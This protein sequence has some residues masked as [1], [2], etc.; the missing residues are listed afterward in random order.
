MNLLFRLIRLISPYR[1]WMLLAV[2]LSYLTVGSSIGLMMTSAW[3][4]AKAALH[5][6]IADLQVAIVGV[7][8]FGI[9]RGVFRYLE[10][11][12][13]HEATFRIL[14]RLRAWF[15]S[16]IEPLVPSGL[17]QFRTADLLSRIAGDVDS[18]EHF[19]IR[20]LAPPAGAVLVLVTMIVLLGHLGANFALVFAVFFLIGGIVVPLFTYWISRSLGRDLV[21]LRSQLSLAAVDAVQG[22]PD[23]LVYGRIEQRLDEFDALNRRYTRL[24]NRL[25]M[26]E[27][28]HE[29]LIGLIMNLAVIGVLRTAAVQMSAGLLDGVLVSVLVLGTMA[30][31]EAVFPLPVAAQHAEEIRRAGVRLF[32]LIG[33][34]P[35]SLLTPSPQEITRPSGEMLEL[36]DVQFTYPGEPV[37]ALEGVSFRLARGQ[38]IALVGP[39]GAGKSTVVNL[40]L[41]FWEPQ[42]GSLLL[43]G[44]P[45]SRI[46]AESWR[47]AFSVVPQQVFLFSGT[48][49]ENLLLARPDAAEEELWEC[50]RLAQLESFVRGLPDGLDSWIGEQGVRIS[51][52]ERQRLA[53]ARALLRKAPV[54]LLDEPTSNLDAETEQK[55]LRALLSREN[56]RSVLLITHRLTALEA[57]DEILVLSRGRIVERGTHRELLARRGVYRHMWD[58]QQQLRALSTLAGA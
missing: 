31:F 8:F 19:F 15:Y 22:L 40:L 46:D 29:A 38:K 3:I 28:G 44:D 39:S 16:A 17:Q 48:V 37:P 50:L 14:A 35:A 2:V 53:I 9:S 52:G 7:R 10:R 1:Y 20:V 32:S 56:H 23:L 4:I 11:L 25:G 49:R 18:L 5:P 43:D 30:A 41:R 33:R 26:L 24:Q 21:E 36:R 55:V 27:A 42:S 51:G 57:V 34:N 54:L 45:P 47:A 12:F 58:E 6:P 13:S